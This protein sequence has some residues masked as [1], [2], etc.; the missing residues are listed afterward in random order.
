MPAEVVASLGAAGFG[1][2]LAG[3]GLGQMAQRAHAHAMVVSM[4]VLAAITAV[5]AFVS[6]AIAWT[7]QPGRK[8]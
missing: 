2:P 8:P 5:L 1:E 6:A 3:K 4:Q 7:T